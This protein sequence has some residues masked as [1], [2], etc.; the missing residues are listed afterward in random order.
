MLA[1]TL[2]S[3]LPAGAAAQS[4]VDALSAAYETNPSLQGARAELRAV[5]EGVPQ[6]L[7]GWRPTVEFT[8]SI[9]YARDETFEPPEPEAVTSHLYPRESELSLTQPLIDAATASDVDSA[10]NLVLAQRADLASTE[11]SVLLKAAQAYL[12]VAE[13]QQVLRLR[14]ETEQALEE[15]IDA[16]V[17]RLRI[18]EATQTDRDQALSRLAGVRAQ[19]ADAVSELNQSRKSFL[20]VTG[21]EAGRLP[22]PGPLG[23]LPADLDGAIVQARQANPEVIAAGFRERAA[24]EEIDKALGALFPTLD[25]TGSLSKN[26]DTLSE[27]SEE[28]TAAVGLSLTVP[29]YQQGIVYSEV[30]QAKQTASQRRLAVEQQRRDAEDAAEQAWQQLVA[31]RRQLTFYQEQV[32]VARQALEGVRREYRL[33]DKTVDDLLDQLIELKNAEID[34]VGA[35]RAEVYAGFQLLAAVGRLNA[36]EL[37]LPV[38]VYDPALDY[39]RVRD[40]WFGL[41]APGVE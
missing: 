7:G 25:L 18:N 8:G 4:L 12:G 24:L 40:A 31:A 37:G 16:I 6:A 30:R 10:E 15:E 5:N 41:E 38:E 36:T 13:D 20:L 34:V 32:R 21:L 14:R 22:M 19:T 27:G 35:E 9:G 2:L 28:T 3:A 33:A 17:R 1:G 39:Q 26:L 29:L 23:G 11:Q